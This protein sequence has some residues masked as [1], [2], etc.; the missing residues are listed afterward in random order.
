LFPAGATLGGI[1]VAI[2]VIDEVLVIRDGTFTKTNL[3]QQKKDLKLIFIGVVIFALGI[4][5]EMYR[6][7]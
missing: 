5:Y 1:G 6:A 7:L 4:L 3:A 2:Y